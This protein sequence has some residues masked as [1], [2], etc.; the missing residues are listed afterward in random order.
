MSKRTFYYARVS[1]KDQK[2]NRQIDAFK[3]LGADDRDI[4]IDKVSGKNLD[5][6]GYQ[7]LKNN[8]LQD[9]DTLVVESLDRLSRNKTNIKNEMEFFREHKIRV[10]VLDIPTTLMDAPE[11]QEW[12]FEMV[13]NILIEVL[14]SFAENERKE[15]KKRQAEG[16]ASAKA[17]GIKLGRPSVQKPDNWDEVYDAWRIGNIT[18][19][20]AMKLT[21]LKKSSFYKFVNEDDSRVE[22]R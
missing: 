15:I 22:K 14:G 9:G 7:A 3:K 6:T 13:E 21:G 10:K 5:R 16:I 8:R 4:I 20:D 1:T 2:V 19:V 12:V 18:A 17:N 11:G